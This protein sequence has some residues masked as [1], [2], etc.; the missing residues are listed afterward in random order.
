MDPQF[1]IMSHGM[2]E[3]PA[4]SSDA[5]LA[6]ASSTDPSILEDRGPM[7]YCSLIANEI[8][9]DSYSVSPA[10]CPPA[11]TPPTLPTDEALLTIM[12]CGQITERDSLQDSAP[13]SCSVL[14]EA[15]APADCVAF[16][17]PS[18][19]IVSEPP[20]LPSNLGSEIF[21]CSI[22]TQA[23]FPSSAPT[24]FAQQE[25]L[26]ATQSNISCARIANVIS[27]TGHTAA[28]LF[29]SQGC[30]RQ[31][32][33][34]RSDIEHTIL[35]LQAG[36]CTYEIEALLQCLSVDADGFIDLAELCRVLRDSANGLAGVDIAA[37]EDCFGRTVAP[38]YAPVSDTN[39]GL[40]TF[41]N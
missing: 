36:I 6:T 17:A 29:V 34:S 2:T 10:E 5:V 35:G 13:H 14:T 38:D 33:L 7:D 3:N 40:S 11:E 12:P 4:L 37:A 19:L 32:R 27:R 28:G 16:A 41:Q 22:V 18:P 9:Y 25:Q 31:G 1:P 30:G 26:L 20:E 8:A 21:E 24:E 15:S 23:H 39:L